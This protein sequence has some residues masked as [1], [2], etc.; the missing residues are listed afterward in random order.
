MHF[1]HSFVQLMCF[2]HVLASSHPTRRI[3]HAGSALSGS[4][5]SYL[6]AD[7]YSVNIFGL[8]NDVN[9]YGS[10][11]SAFGGFGCN[12]SNT[13]YPF[14][15]STQHFYAWRDHGFNLFR[16]PIAWQHAQGT[17]GGPLNETTMK[18]YDAL[19]DT[20]TSNGSRAM[21]DIVS[22]KGR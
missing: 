16:L 13:A 9:T 3:K 8:A 20:I 15:D 22:Q 17:L 14:Y 19:V 21:I 12:A 5:T 6:Y 7:N 1:H 18:H 2:A 11:Y 10:A 4:Q